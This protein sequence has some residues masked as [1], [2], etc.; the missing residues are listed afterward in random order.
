IFNDGRTI[1]QSAEPSPPGLL[2]GR[3]GPCTIFAVRDIV[4]PGTS[5]GGLPEMQNRR[6]PA[7][8]GVRVDLRS[9]A[10]SRRLDGRGRL[11]LTASG[12]QGWSCRTWAAGNS[13]I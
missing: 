12:D 13:I 7:G 6:K 1:G 9:P 8:D 3:N 4:A 5:P 11:R 2:P 10:S